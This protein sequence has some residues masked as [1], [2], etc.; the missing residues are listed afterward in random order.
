MKKLVRISVVSFAYGFLMYGAGAQLSSGTYSSTPSNGQTQLATLTL[1]VPKN[2]SNSVAFPLSTNQI[3][4]FKTFPTSS[5]FL[6]AS[7]TFLDGTTI[8]IPSTS[9]PSTS[10]PAFSFTGAI[11]ISMTISGNATQPLV[12][13]MMTFNVFTPSTNSISVT[14]VNSVVI[15]SDATGPVQIILESSSDLVNWVPSLPG[16]YGN[17]YTNRFFRVRAVAQ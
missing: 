1:S 5:T 14:P 2:G 9:S 10:E 8:P 15:P 3:V 11:N 13:E 17:T 16:T 7:V 4:T 12:T 6:T